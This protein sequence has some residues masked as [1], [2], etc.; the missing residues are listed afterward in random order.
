MADSKYKPVPPAE[1]RW[2]KGQSGN[3]AGK[4]KR[5]VEAERQ[6]LITYAEFIDLVTKFSTM[7]RDEIKAY[8]ERPEATMFELIYGK[9]V[10]DAAK[11][12]RVAREMLT[13]RLFGKVKEQI[14]SFNVNVNSTPEGPPIYVVEMHDNGKFVSQTPK[15]L[16]T[17]N[18]DE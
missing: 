11:G 5:V 16:K 17:S 4:A 2:K 12:D 8:L 13:E 10:V 9:M 15:L 3:P 14:E 1:H 7:P 18:S 6:R